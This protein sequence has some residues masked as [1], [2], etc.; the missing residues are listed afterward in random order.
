MANSIF[1]IVVWLIEFETLGDTVDIVGRL[2]PSFAME[3][4]FC[5]GC[6]EVELWKL[7][8]TKSR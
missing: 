1:I 8:P 4:I 7:V 5:F 2:E 3:D 6:S